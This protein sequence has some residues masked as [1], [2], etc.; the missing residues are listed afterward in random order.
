MKKSVNAGW[1][2]DD[3]SEPAKSLVVSSW[4]GW[5]VSIVV[6]MVHH[7]NV[8]SEWELLLAWCFGIRP[9]VAICHCALKLS[10]EL[11][12]CAHHLTSLWTA[13]SEGCMA[14]TH[15]ACLPCSTLVFPFP[16]HT[17][18]PFLG[19]LLWP[20]PRTAVSLSQYVI[21]S[22]CLLRPQLQHFLHATNF[23][24][25]S[26]RVLESCGI[27]LWVRTWKRGCAEGCLRF[28]HVSAILLRCDENSLFVRKLNSI[29]QKPG[30]PGTRNG[31]Q[32]KVCSDL[33]FWGSPCKKS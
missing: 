32:L 26:T 1:D 31:R 19:A 15:T 17:A 8:A 28:E 33:C 4:H 11:R 6:R 16:K 12:D 3:W 7:S 24:Y 21:P 2:I 29:G 14:T 13:P 22:S 25:F 9:V 18:S 20:T 10:F 5:V 27:N 23:P 30:V